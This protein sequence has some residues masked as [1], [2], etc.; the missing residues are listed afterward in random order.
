[1][2]CYSSS[3]LHNFSRLPSLLSRTDFWCFFFF[4]CLPQLYLWGSRFFF[5]FCLPLLYLWGSRFFFF[6][7]LSQLYLWGSPFFFFFCVPLLYL[8]GSPFFFFFCL[9][10]LYLFKKK[11][12]GEPQKKKN[13]KPRDIAGVCLFVGWLLYVPATGSC[14]SGTDLLRQFYVLPH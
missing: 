3:G 13:G 11:K 2:I 6:F 7:C 1:M 5:F 4:F 14:I 12:N 10:Q 8:W 9:P